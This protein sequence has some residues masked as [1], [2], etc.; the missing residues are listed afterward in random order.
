[1]LTSIT[2]FQGELGTIK[3]V[4]RFLVFKLETRYYLLI[5]IL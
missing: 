5:M 3:H 1:M 2:I 4:I